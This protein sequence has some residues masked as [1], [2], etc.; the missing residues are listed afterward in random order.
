[1][2]EQLFAE[3]DRLSAPGSRVGVEWVHD[4]A[5]V[6]EQ[7]AFRQSSANLEVDLAE[8][9]S[10]EPRTPGDERLRGHGWAVDAAALREVG[11]H[12]RPFDASSGAQLI[13][14]RGRLATAKR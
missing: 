5:A 7:A 8:V 10:A 4:V 12:G 14:D 6:V 3:I 1:M 11:A 13:G 2:A 9:W